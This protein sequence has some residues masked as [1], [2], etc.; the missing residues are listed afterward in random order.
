MTIEV[1]LLGDGRV[2]K[3]DDRTAILGGSFYYSPLRPYSPLPL[4]WCYDQLIRYPKAVLIDVGS[5]TGSFGLLSALH[6]DLTV[7]AFEPVPLTYEV[8]NEN[9]KLNGLQDKVSTHP[10]GI[11]NYDGM[12]VAYVVTADGGKGVSIVDGSPAYHKV[13]EQLNIRVLTL[14][15][16]C[17]KHGVVPTF[18]KID[19]EGAEQ[20]VLEGATGIIEKYH[21]FLLFEYSQE[22]ADQFGLTMSKTIE[23]VES[24]GYVWSNPEQTDI[25]AVH[26]DWDKINKLAEETID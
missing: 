10:I 3:V 8:L 17:S 21:P 14:D 22:N 9:V 26:V 7:Y 20:L 4:K 12:G 5:S 18:I 15:T 16:F 23:M 19:V 1:D 6:P 25:W 24:W 13:V 2:V 11:S